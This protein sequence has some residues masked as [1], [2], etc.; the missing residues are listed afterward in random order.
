MC[1]LYNISFN[2]NNEGFAICDNSLHQFN[3]YSHFFTR[4]FQTKIKNDKEYSRNVHTS[5]L[6]NDTKP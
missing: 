3:F 2:F 1:K 5:F 6:T 4:R